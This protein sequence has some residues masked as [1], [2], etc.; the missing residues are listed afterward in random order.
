MK[1]LKAIAAMALMLLATWASAEQRHFWKPTASVPFSFKVGDKVLPAGEYQV[2]L[3]GTSL[4]LTG[5]SGEN[6]IVLSHGVQMAAPAEKSRLEFVNNN[7]TLQLYRVWQAGYNSGREL[8]LPTA[9]R[10]IAQQSG[11]T[12]IPVRL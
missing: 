7:G 5:E 9:E 4:V 2:R 11:T 10:K 1:T 3:E 8:S 12:E 6:V